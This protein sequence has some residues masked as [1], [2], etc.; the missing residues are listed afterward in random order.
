MAGRWR[1][2]HTGKKAKCEKKGS[3]SVTRMR[4]RSLEFSAHALTLLVVFITASFF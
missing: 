2:R 4:F 3:W 1:T